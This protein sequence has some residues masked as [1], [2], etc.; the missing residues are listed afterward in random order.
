V[1]EL[2]KTRQERLQE[3]FRPYSEYLARHGK[4]QF[5]RTSYIS[6]LQSF[7][8]WFETANGEEFSPGAVTPVDVQ[9]T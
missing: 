8:N 9:D 3:V 5:T 7:V 2:R 4:S 6:D 1:G